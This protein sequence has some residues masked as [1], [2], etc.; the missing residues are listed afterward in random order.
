MNRVRGR[1]QR[2]FSL[3]EMIV[4]MVI[5]SLSLGMLYQAAAGATRNVR[6]DERYSY[7]VLLAQSLLA[8]HSVLAGAGV[9]AGGEIEDYR[10][11]LSS[12]LL[13][14]AEGTGQIALH[15]LTAAIEWRD[16]DNSRQVVLVTVVPEAVPDA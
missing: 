7:A 13:P 5:L 16:G 2:G 12:T 8:E 10:W 1:S 3:I 11:R 15:Q 14:G 6:V 9:S 4:A